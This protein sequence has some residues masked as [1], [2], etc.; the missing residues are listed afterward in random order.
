M[1]RLRYIVTAKPYAHYLRSSNTHLFGL[2]ALVPGCFKVA[3]TNTDALNK[4]A[5]SFDRPDYAE[6]CSPI[7]DAPSTAIAFTLF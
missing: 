2:E 5:N 6:P 1:E 7:S 3:Y 4:M